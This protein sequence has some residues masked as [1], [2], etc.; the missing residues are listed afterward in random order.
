MNSSIG[1]KHMHHHFKI[2]IKAKDLKVVFYNLRLRNA[3]TYVHN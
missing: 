2:S 3:L 1:G